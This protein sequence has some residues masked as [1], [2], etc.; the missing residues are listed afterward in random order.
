M[1]SLNYSLHET[2]LT[3]EIGLWACLWDCPDELNRGG[4]THTIMGG[5]IPWG[6]IL[7]CVEETEASN[8]FLVS[9]LSDRR[10]ST[11]TCLSTHCFNFPT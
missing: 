10:C 1:V 5:I 6:G 2:T 3:W 8:A 11:T 9:L 7:D 4:K